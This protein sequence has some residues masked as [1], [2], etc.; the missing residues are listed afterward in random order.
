MLIKILGMAIGAAVVVAGLV[1]R[2]KEKDDRESRK[3]YGVIA[4][5]GALLFFGLLA[6]LVF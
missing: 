4:A 1:L 2:A 3:I 5:V 6:L